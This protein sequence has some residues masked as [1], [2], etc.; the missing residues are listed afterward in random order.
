V[1]TPTYLCLTSEQNPFEL[2]DLSAATSSSYLGKEV[3]DLTSGNSSNEEK[4]PFGVLIEKVSK[5]VRSIFEKFLLIAL[6]P[7]IEFS[8]I[9][10]YYTIIKKLPFLT[11]FSIASNI[12]IAIFSLKKIFNTESAIDVDFSNYCENLVEKAREKPFSVFDGRQNELDKLVQTLLKKEKNNALL[13]GPAGCGKTA[14]IN[15]LAQRISEGNVPDSLKGKEIISLNMLSLISGTTY[16]GDFEARVEMILKVL[17]EDPEHYILFIDEGHLISKSGDKDGNQTLANFLKPVLA[18][19]LS[20]VIATTP[21]EYVE[22]LSPDQALVRRFDFIEIESLNTEAMI[23][24]L[25]N[26]KK[27]RFEDKYKLTIDDDVI[28]YAVKKAH[29]LI[30]NIFP[31]APLTLLENACSK[32]IFKNKKIVTVEDVEETFNQML[33]V[34]EFMNHP[35]PTAP[36][37]GVING[38]IA[39]STGGGGVMP[40]Q[41]TKMFSENPFEI[42]LTGV[43]GEDLVDSVNVAKNLAWNLLP[44]NLRKEIFKKEKYGFHLHFPPGG[45]SK[46]GPSAGAAIT[47]A[48]FSRL[49]NI[50]LRHNVAMTGEI[51]SLGNITAIGGVQNKLQGAIDKGIKQVFLP[52]GNEKEF[53]EALTNLLDLVVK[54]KD[55]KD[56]TYNELYQ[57]EELQIILVEKIEELLPLVLEEDISHLS[58]VA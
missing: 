56:V 26:I 34:P 17:K 55:A 7:S 5:V 25:M 49:A 33:T 30:P 48:M 8:S 28:Y 51:D 3:K 45:I 19:G 44:L 40:I 41:V 14:L 37:I 57:E 53:N 18:E 46:D 50:P 16:R 9:F 15:N 10:C 32:S 36:T 21:Q 31:D 1:T 29:K 6:E 11:S 23:S 22:Y 47:C 2:I 13:V 58:K 52:K 24:V 20:C 38:L 12:V 39:F 27:E 54:V 35:I 43:L 4:G 42:K